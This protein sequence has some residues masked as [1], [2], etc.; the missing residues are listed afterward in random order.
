MVWITGASSGIGAALARELVAQGATV[1][2]S[3]RRIDRLNALRDEL[4]PCAHIYPL[5]VENEHQVDETA[6]NIAERFGGIDVVVANAGY[7]VLAPFEKITADIWRKQLEVNLFGVIWTLKAAQK[8]IEKAK[9]RMAITS[10]VAGLMSYPKGAAY[11]ASKYALF[12]IAN[13]LYQELH[14]KGVSVTIFAPG[15]VESEI[16]LAD[17]HGRKRERKNAGGY[18]KWHWPAERAAKVMIDGLYK[19]KREVVVTG[20]GK[21]G[22][23]IFKH[24]GSFGYWCLA[25]AKL[26]VG[27]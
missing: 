2:L 10:S 25:R 4:G 15:F 17:N 22:A 7:S 5:D 16:H 26:D 20:H 27:H 21:L 14:K 18:S 23:F 13:T 19:R 24:F 9:G 11:S 8:H 12:G 3:A 6:K 1:A